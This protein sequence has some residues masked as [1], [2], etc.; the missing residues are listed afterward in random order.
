ML[1]R[2]N[3]ST[4]YLSRNGTRILDGTQ[5]VLDVAGLVPVV[6]EFADGANALI[7]LGRGDNTNAAL[8]GAAMIPFVGWG[9]TTVKVAGKVDNAVGGAEILGKVDGKTIRS[10]DFSIVDW[11]GYPAGV[12][13]PAGVGAHLKLTQAAR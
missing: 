6:G 10:G 2:W 3:S 5:T 11:A 4:D 7:Y 12:P 8:S 9:A 13:K 1:I